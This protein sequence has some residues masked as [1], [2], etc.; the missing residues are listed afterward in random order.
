MLIS[1]YYR[2]QNAQL[3]ESI[4]GYGESSAK[5]APTVQQIA[6]GLNTRD[7]LDYGCGKRKLEEA[8][9]YPI[10][11]YDPAI[12]GLDARPERA[13]VVV[14]SDVL[15]HIEPECLDDVLNDLQRVT[16]KA[17]F[18]VISTRKAEKKL[19]DGRNAHLIVKPYQWW[20]PK[21][22]DRFSILQYNKCIGEFFVIVKG[23]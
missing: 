4:P 12:P 7:I 1:D 9:G 17:G 8:L 21:L 3:H 18:F 14:C 20:L 16:R 15:E 6:D 2:N 5:W 10:K 11:N 19:P 23:F 22:W 13:D